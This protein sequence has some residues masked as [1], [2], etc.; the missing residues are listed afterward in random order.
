VNFYRYRIL[1]GIDTVIFFDSIQS[2]PKGLKLFPI[3][4]IILLRKPG[5]REGLEL[6]I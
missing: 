2:T 6:R 5:K 3:R 1:L 4:E